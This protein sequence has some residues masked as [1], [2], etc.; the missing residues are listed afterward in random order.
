MDRMPESFG[1]SEVDLVWEKYKG[2][3]IGILVVILVAS[4]GYNIWQFQNQAKTR[5]ATQ[6]FAAAKSD[7]DFKQIAQDFAGQPVGGNALLMLAADQM[8]KKDFTAARAT[9]EEFVQKNP[10]HPLAPAGVYA[11]AGLLENENKLDE[12]LARYK[13]IGEKY[14]KSFVEDAALTGRARVLVAKNDVDGARAIYQEIIGKAEEKS[15]ARASAEHELKLLNR[16]G[17]TFS[18]IKYSDPTPPMPKAPSPF[19]GLPGVEGA[20]GNTLNLNPSNA[21]SVSDIQSALE[22]ALKRAAPNNGPGDANDVGLPEI[23]S[24][25]D[26][27]LPAAL[28][29]ETPAPSSVPAPANSDAPQAAAPPTP[30]EPAS[31]DAP[32]TVPANATPQTPGAPQP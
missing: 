31:T 13:E 14:P 27:M 7:A 8:A 1:P 10:K 21:G 16:I 22:S 12:A 30:Q 5:E 4:V 24:A 15:Q 19:P 23:P 6:R 32:A 2:L 25:P 26:A 17:E 20:E 3:I 29:P 28:S 9:Y 18:E 11:I